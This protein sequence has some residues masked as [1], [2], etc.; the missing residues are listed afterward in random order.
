MTDEN[1]I[2]NHQK[3]RSRTSLLSLEIGCGQSTNHPIRIDFTLYSK[4]NV[5]GNADSL[6]FLDQCFELI[7]SRYMFEHLD[8]PRKA[9]EEWKRVLIRDGKVEIVTDNASYWR[10][11]LSLPKILRL[12]NPHQQYVGT[13]IKDKH[14]A[15]YLPMHIRNHLEALDFRDILIRYRDY[16]PLSILLKLIGI[17][18]LAAASI[19]AVARRS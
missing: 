18:S 10:N 13:T 9:L 14:Y 12:S 16:Y 3:I 2:T 1:M 6:P 7:Y 17:E 15:I 4:A 11:H 5:I 8:N 19:R